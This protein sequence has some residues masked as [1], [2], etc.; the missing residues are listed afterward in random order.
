[1]ARS[2]ADKAAVAQ[3]PVAR[4]AAAP[5]ARKVAA[6]RVVVRKAVPTARPAELAAKRAAPPV[7]AA[8]K[9]AAVLPARM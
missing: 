7:R 9:M 4:R 2:P 1:V 6:V 5:A 8:D 3:T